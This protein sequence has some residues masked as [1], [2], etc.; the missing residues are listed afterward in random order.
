[1]TSITDGL[2]SL[3]LAWKAIREMRETKGFLD[4]IEFLDSVIE[5]GESGTALEMMKACGVPARFAFTL[6]DGWEGDEVKK[7]STVGGLLQ[8]TRLETIGFRVRHY[9]GEAFAQTDWV[10]V[11]ARFV[12]RWAELQKS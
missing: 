10:G 12:K 6:I 4:A 11:R 1:M 5:S 9:S 2:A 7:L 8:W 3:E